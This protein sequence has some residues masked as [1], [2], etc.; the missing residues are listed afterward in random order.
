[1]AAEGVSAVGATSFVS[2]PQNRAIPSTRSLRRRVSRLFGALASSP[3]LARGLSRARGGAVER[4]WGGGPLGWVLTRDKGNFD[5]KI[6]ANGEETPVEFDAHM[7]VIGWTTSASSLP[8]GE[9]SLVVSNETGSLV[10]ADAVRWQS[11]EE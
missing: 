8:A 11:V 1:M 7:A 6:V 5:L 2:V 3:P 9:V 10:V 4:A